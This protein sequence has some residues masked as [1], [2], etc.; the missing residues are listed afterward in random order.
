MVDKYFNINIAISK[1]LK[2]KGFIKIFKNKLDRK[3]IISNKKRI[4]Q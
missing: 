3:I 2:S 1:K 4:E